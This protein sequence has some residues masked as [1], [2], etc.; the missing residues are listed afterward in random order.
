MRLL[1]ILPRFP[2]PIEKGDKLRA[3]HQLRI[4]SQYHQIHLVA[5]SHQKIE[6]KDL[7]KVRRFCKTVEV[8]RIGWISVAYNLLK[9]FFQGLPFQVGYYYSAKA[10]KRVDKAVENFKPEHIYCQ[11]LRTAAYGHRYNIPAT[12][13]YQDVFSKGIERRIPGVK[14]IMKWLLG[15]EYKRLLSYEHWVFEH[16]SNKTIIS[17][18]D[19]DCIPHPKRDQIVIVPNG[20]DHSFFKPMSIP[21][22]HDLVFTGNMGYPPNIN[23]AEYLAKKVLPIVR[24]KMPE[25]KLL[26]AGATPHQKVKSLASEHITVTGWVDD[27]R[28]CYAGARIFLAP[29]Q[30]GTGLQNKLLE[31]MS[32]KMPCITSSLCNSALKAAPGIEILIGDSPKQVA[33]HIISL[34]NDSALSDKIATAGYDFVHRKYSWEGATKE[35]LRVIGN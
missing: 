33:D 2:Y 11:L 35:L 22:G 34:L 8:V 19:R 4:L 25:V 12:I 32:M 17:E 16:F 3:Y 5:I 1:V 15:M 28:E 26:I 30:L 10:Q 7:E 20:V 27:I 21:V 29:M 14:G 13:D 6:A 24:K 9:V 18:P 23:C 31:A